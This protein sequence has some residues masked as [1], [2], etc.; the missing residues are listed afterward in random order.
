MLKSLIAL[1]GFR[2]SILAGLLAIGFGSSAVAQEGERE[3]P[4][5]A[6][7][8]PATTWFDPKICARPAGRKLYVR[9]GSAVLALPPEN[10]RALMPSQISRMTSSAGKVMMRIGRTAGCPE[11]PFPTV[12]VT[13]VGIKN[14][15]AGTIVLSATPDNAAAFDA[16]L[17]K[18]RDSGSCP[19]ASPGLI[20]C[21][22]S[23]TTASGR[24][25]VAYV[26]AADPG[27]RQTSGGPLR[28]LCILE[29][30]ERCS[31]LDD[32]PGGLRFESAVGKAPSLQKLQQI[33]AQGRS[34]VQSLRVREE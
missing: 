25:D 30:P 26:M 17:A 4:S 31:V 29:G 24:Q 34:F 1:R 19:V 28:A 5:E 12:A 27:M 16:Q 11:A 7:G 15:G 3:L 9:I 20:H 14:V 13:L 23:R 21:K 2:S 22:G 33:D 6:L 10:V 32:L 8:Q 18:I